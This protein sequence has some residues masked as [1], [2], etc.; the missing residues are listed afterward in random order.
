[1]LLRHFQRHF[2]RPAGIACPSHCK[3]EVMLRGANF[4]FHHLK[5]PS[6]T[7][8]VSPPWPPLE[9]PFKPPSKLNFLFQPAAQTSCGRTRCPGLAV[10]RQICCLAEPRFS[11]LLAG[12]RPTAAWAEVARAANHL[13][14]RCLVRAGGFRRH[15]TASLFPPHTLA[16]S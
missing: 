14:F 4:Q 7:E 2:A 12:A 5:P 6:P 3:T 1:L 8:K 13:V 15:R 9:R 11:L 10:C 16:A